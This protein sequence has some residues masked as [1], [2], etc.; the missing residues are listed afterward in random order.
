M[1]MGSDLPTLLKAN[2][3]NCHPVKPAATPEGAK[4]VKVDTEVIIGASGHFPAL[5]G[6]SPCPRD[7]YRGGR[8]GLGRFGSFLY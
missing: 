5:A 1:E 8:S 6:T 7:R 4:D 2:H 3:I